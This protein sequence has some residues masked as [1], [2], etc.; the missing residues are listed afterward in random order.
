MKSSV[1]YKYNVNFR[2]FVVFWYEVFCSVTNFI[3]SDFHSDHQ[4]VKYESD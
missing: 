4:N 3:V 1:S 2:F